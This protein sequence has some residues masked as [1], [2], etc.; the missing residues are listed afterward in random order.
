MRTLNDLKEEGCSKHWEKKENAPFP[1]VFSTL[2]E[3][4]SLLIVVYK[5]F[6]FGHVQSCSLL[7]SK[8]L[9]IYRPIWMKIAQIMWSSA[10]CQGIRIYCCHG[11]KELHIKFNFSSAMH[12]LLLNGHYFMNVHFFFSESSVYIH[13]HLGIIFLLPVSVVTYVHFLWMQLLIFWLYLF[14]IYSMA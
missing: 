1:T 12:L 14:M 8:L 3:K 10:Y 13:I 4:L 6:Q 11:K 5:C 2:R 7:K 9:D